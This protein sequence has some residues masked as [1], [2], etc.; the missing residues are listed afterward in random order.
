MLKLTTDGLPQP[1]SPGPVV[2]VIVLAAVAGAGLL[3]VL[4]RPRSGG[5]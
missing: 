1:F 3:V 4:R 5:R 2:L